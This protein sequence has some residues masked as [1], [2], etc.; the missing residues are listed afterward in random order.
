MA[1]KICQGFNIKCSIQGKIGYN[2]FP[3]PRIKLN[4]FII[5]DPVAKDKTLGTVKN[6]V[7]KLSFYNLLNKKKLNFNKIKLQIAQISFDLDKLNE[8]KNFSKKEFNSEFINLEKSEIKFF[9]GEKNITTIKNVNFK[10]KPKKKGDEAILKGDFLDD[11]IYISLKNRK[12]KNNPTKFLKLKFLDA[13]AKL[14]ILKSNL[15]NNTITRT[16]LLSWV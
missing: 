2:F 13:N 1:N 9:D 12:E 11:D 8:Y 15:D 4:N 3:S 6:V 7:I 5:K 16:Y 10:Y 14:S